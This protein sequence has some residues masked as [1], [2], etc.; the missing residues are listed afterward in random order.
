MYAK[1]VI[2]LWAL[3][4]SAVWSQKLQSEN[5][6][7]DLETSE[8]R[9]YGYYRPYGGYGGLVRATPR[10]VTTLSASHVSPPSGTPCPVV[11]GSLCMA[12]SPDAIG[13]EARP[14]QSE[15][16]PDVLKNCQPESPSGPIEQ[17]R[18]DEPDG[19]LSWLVNLSAAS[20][21]TP[22][23]NHAPKTFNNPLRCYE[24][25]DSVNAKPGLTY[26]ELIEKALKEKGELTVSEIY[27]WIYS[28]YPYYKKN[29]GRWKNSIRHN[30]S[31]NP[32]FRK[33]EKCN[34]GG[35]FWTLNKE[36]DEEFKKW[37]VR[38]GM[39]EE[40]RRKKKEDD[41]LEV[42]TRSIMLEDDTSD[43]G[44]YSSK[45]DPTLLRVANN[46]L[47]G[48]DE[49]VAV[50]FMDRTGDDKWQ[51]DVINEASRMTALLQKPDLLSE[52]EKQT[53]AEDGF[54]ESLDT[55]TAPMVIEEDIFEN[56]DPILTDR[57]P[58]IR[59]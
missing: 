37:E 23:G 54:P 33:G 14:F 30:L 38:K 35:H 3:I 15:M 51:N 39:K 34:N 6:E 4:I 25:Y 45:E 56:S 41:E 12:S 43:C 8:A 58:P 10:K 46:I 57:F 17:C 24:E 49:K 52:L 5:S 59:A 16:V 18:S 11:E 19:N 53:Y 36:Y 50:E 55:H 22:E 47:N 9:Y 28:K 31:I 7:E 48:I 40:K 26:T 29:D 32:Q 42:A 13:V 44:S 2:F 1:V 27:K 21:F 20:L